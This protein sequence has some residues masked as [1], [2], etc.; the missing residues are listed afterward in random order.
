MSNDVLHQAAVEDEKSGGVC[1]AE[2]TSILRSLS[3]RASRVEAEIT[4][5]LRSEFASLVKPPQ[6]IAVA[7]DKR[8]F[9]TY[10]R[11]ESMLLLIHQYLLTGFQ[12]LSC[13]GG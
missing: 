7:G 11:Y 2:A 8:Y 4:R 1:D 9:C 10:S 6:I 12:C 13:M 3:S 5:R